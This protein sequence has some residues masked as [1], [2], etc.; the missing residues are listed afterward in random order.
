M[1]LT[2]QLQHYGLISILL[3]W[4][5]AITIVG[6][7]S[8]GLW[9]TSLGY[10]DSWYKQAPTIHKSIGILLAGVWVF[11]VLWNLTNTKPQPLATH[12]PTEKKLAYLAHLTLYVL[13]GCIMVSGYLISTADDRA[14]SVFGWFEIPA[15]LTSIEN[16]EDIAGD[17]HFYLALSLI[18]LASLHALAAIKHHLIDKDDTLRRVTSLSMLNR[19]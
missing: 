8:L 19:H 1:K 3:H 15:T 18:S 2:N 11:R 7:F 10:Y 17:I 5:M 4:V 9:M 6:L 12:T 14:I 16:Q 13:M